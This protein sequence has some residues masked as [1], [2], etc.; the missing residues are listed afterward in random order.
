MSD[1]MLR[2]LADQ[3]ALEEALDMG[4]PDDVP[5]EPGLQAELAEHGPDALRD[6]NQ[7]VVR[8]TSERKRFNTALWFAHAHDLKWVNRPDLD[9]VILTWQDGQEPHDLNDEGSTT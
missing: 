1:E 9:C 6:Y 7:I 4:E 8:G 5:Y 2:R 3:A